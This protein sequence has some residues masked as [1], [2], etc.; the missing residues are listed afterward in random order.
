[1]SYPSDLTDV[2]WELIREFFKCGNRSIH[3]KR[4]LVNA[5]RY[6]T[7]TGCQWR[8]LP[9]DFPCWPTVH[10]FFRRARLKGLWEAILKKLVKESRE[11]MERNS[12]PSYAIVDSQSSKTTGAAKDRGIDGGKKNK[13]SK[14]THCN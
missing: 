7:K 9:N 1:M 2:E 6:I 4:S 13:G 12:E 5:V 14:K 10:S 11:Q 8:Q 3:E